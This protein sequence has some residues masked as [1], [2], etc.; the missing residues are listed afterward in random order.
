MIHKHF[1]ADNFFKAKEI[2]FVKIL[3]NREF[4]TQVSHKACVFDI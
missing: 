3:P 4:K 2:V 1:S